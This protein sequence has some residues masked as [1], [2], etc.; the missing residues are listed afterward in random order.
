MHIIPGRC[1]C[2][3]Q[4]AIEDTDYFPEYFVEVYNT[5]NTMH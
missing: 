4:I 5:N 3:S 2:F 1:A